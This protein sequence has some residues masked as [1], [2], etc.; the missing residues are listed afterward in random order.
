MKVPIA[1]SYLT[2]RLVS[3][4]KMKEFTEK[5]SNQSVFT[6]EEIKK[7]KLEIE[8]ELWFLMTLK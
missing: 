5:R 4:K 1:I 3:L 6:L 7:E 8:T 2:K